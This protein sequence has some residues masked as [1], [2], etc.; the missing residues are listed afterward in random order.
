MIILANYRNE[1][2][3]SRNMK[4]AMRF[5]VNSRFS[6]WTRTFSRIGTVAICCIIV[7]YYTA[8]AQAKPNIIL[9]LSDDAGFHDFGFQVSN[10]IRTQNLER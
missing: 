2:K 1:R 9:I 5:C 7:P 8:M 6:I 4:I 10:E 3:K